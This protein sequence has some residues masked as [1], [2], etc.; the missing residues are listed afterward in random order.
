[1]RRCRRGRCLSI[2]HFH[3]QFCLDAKDLL[4]LDPGDEVDSDDA[5]RRCK[6]VMTEAESM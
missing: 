6:R 5:D 3:F 4:A 1:M 2:L